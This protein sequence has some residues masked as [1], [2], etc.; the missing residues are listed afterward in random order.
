MTLLLLL[1]HGLHKILRREDLP[2][3]GLG[4]VQFVLLAFVSQYGNGNPEITIQPVKQSVASLITL[5][6]TES[7]FF[8]LTFTPIYDGTRLMM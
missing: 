6:R 8:R 1:F 4:C 2:F 7:K 3:F 5:Q